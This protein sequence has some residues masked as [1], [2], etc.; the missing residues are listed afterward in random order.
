MNIYVGNLS[1][2]LNDKDLEK[3]FSPFGAVTES[4]IIIDRDTGRSKGFGF[5]EMANQA[6]GEE[7]IKQLDGKEIDGRKI[8]VNEAKPKTDR[9]RRGPRY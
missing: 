1:Y 2:G 6:E 7:A 5:V 9:P 4:K 8:K 3:L